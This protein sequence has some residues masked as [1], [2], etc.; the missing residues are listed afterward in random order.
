MLSRPVVLDASV[1]LNLLATGHAAELIRSLGSQG[2]VCSAVVNETLYIRSEGADDPPEMVNLQ[3]LLDAGTLEP[4]NLRGSNEHE[5]FV[6][7]ATD[8]DDGEAM[9]LALCSA[10]SFVL[11]TDDGKARRIASLSK[12]IDTIDTPRERIANSL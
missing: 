2:L 1:L 7:Y 6:R 12:G 4:C 5:L 9:S 8:L 11:A 3:P 10:R